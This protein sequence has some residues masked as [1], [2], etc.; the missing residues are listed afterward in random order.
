MKRS[1][2]WDRRLP[3]RVDAA[4]GGVVIGGIQGIL[5]S[6]PFSREAR[7][8]GI[9][10]MPRDLAEVAQFA[11]LGATSSQGGLQGM[12]LSMLLTP[13]VA[14]AF[15][16]SSGDGENLDREGWLLLTISGI[17]YWALTRG[18]CRVVARFLGS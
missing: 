8:V 16:G 18:I 3:R 2:K 11:T 4:V 10:S 13:A 7:S 14:M 9:R 12:G 1:D 6:L 15:S 17:G 5:V